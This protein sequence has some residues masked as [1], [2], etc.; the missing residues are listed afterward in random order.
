MAQPLTTARRLK[1][2]PHYNRLHPSLKITSSLRLAGAWLL[3]TGF[4]SG[5]VATIEVRE[6][7]LIS[8]RV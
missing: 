1:V 5:E 2:A 7:R 3:R 6:G 8:T 4:R